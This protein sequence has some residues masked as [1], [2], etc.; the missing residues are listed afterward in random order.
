M[1]LFM[2]LLTL[3]FIAV[4][5]FLSALFIPFIL[6]PLRLIQYL[7]LINMKKIIS[8]FLLLFSHDL[9]ACGED[10]SLYGKY[11]GGSSGSTVY[12]PNNAVF[13]LIGAASS[14]SSGQ[15][16][17]YGGGTGGMYVHSTTFF[18]ENGGGTSSDPATFTYYDATPVYCPSG[19][20]FD[21]KGQ[22]T[23][24]SS[25]NVVDP[26]THLCSSPACPSGTFPAPDKTCVPNTCPLGTT[27]DSVTQHCVPIVCPTGQK[28]LSDGVCHNPCPVNSSLIADLTCHWDCPHW[29]KSKCGTYSASDGQSCLWSPLSNTSW[30]GSC[31]NKTDFINHWGQI[32]PI[33]TTR[34]SGN[35]YGTWRNGSIGAAPKLP[36]W[37][38]IPVKP[39]EPFP[40]EPAPSKP[41]NDPA[42][43]PPSPTPV[44]DP[45]P[46]VDPTPVPVDPVPVVD[47][48]PSPVVPDS[49]TPVPTPDPLTS[50]LPS[51][52]PAP[53]PVPEPVIAPDPL[54]SPFH[55]PLPVP[56]P[57]PS[58]T[59]L[60]APA[61]IT[62]TTTV[63]PDPTTTTNPPTVT[64][65]TTVP[66]NPAPASDPATDPNTYYGDV[67]YPDVPSITNFDI[68]D[69][70]H[71]RYNAQTMVNNVLDQVDNVQ[72]T[73]ENTKNILD[74]GF[75]PI[76]LPVGACGQSMIIN[77]YGKTVDLCPPLTETTSK[78]HDLFQLI[79]FLVGI[80][81][82]IKIFI[83]GLRD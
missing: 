69:L 13:Y 7:R 67:I 43:V 55:D 38:P 57:T 22:C 35:G 78:Y 51:P 77:F 24:C 18:T 52:V 28:L 81:L 4:S 65:T 54:P 76:V 8:L 19:Q 42:Y 10:I 40:I 68:W 60:P 61:P 32:L 56:A 15:T 41:A 66:F 6:S 12:N 25:P 9:F 47:P 44:I 30:T 37:E 50:P 62:V 48:T 27:R 64:T 33:A 45:I 72:N 17:S 20:T 21:T 74:H 23:T 80:V 53:L 82:S 39:S 1:I 2:L 46:V 16:C 3:F 70:D 5:A 31:L 29:S 59:P 73:F 26:N 36:D 75:Q 58:T 34:V 83:S 14:T 79:V 71:F 63:A 11:V 49:P